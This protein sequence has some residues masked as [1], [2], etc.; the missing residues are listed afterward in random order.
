M[1][2]PVLNTPQCEGAS[3]FPRIRRGLRT[4]VYSFGSHGSSP[5]T[6]PVGFLGSYATA[7]SHWAVDGSS[8]PT[9]SQ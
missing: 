8:L 7:Y 2:P 6:A 3:R 9:H 4:A 1:Y 5:I